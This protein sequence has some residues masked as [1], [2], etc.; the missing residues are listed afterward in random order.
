MYP[1]TLI[2]YTSFY[3]VSLPRDMVQVIV[4]VIFCNIDS[5]LYCIISMSIETCY[6]ISH[7]LKKNPMITHSIYNYMFLSTTL[8]EGSSEQFPILVM[9]I[10]GSVSH[11]RPLHLD[12]QEICCP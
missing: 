10:E 2:W 12:I 4:P 9:S 1:Q 5:P 6:I 3:N 8:Q 11:S 7:I